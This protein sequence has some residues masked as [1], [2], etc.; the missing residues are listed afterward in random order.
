MLGDEAERT[1]PSAAEYLLARQVRTFVASRHHGHRVRTACVEQ[2]Y[3]EACG[4]IPGDPTTDE[5][6]NMQDDADGMRV[7]K[8]LPIGDPETKRLK[9]AA[10]VEIDPRNPDDLML[11]ID[12][13]GLIDIGFNVP[14]FIMP[15]DIPCR[16]ALVWDVQAFPDHQ[17]RSS[18]DTTSSSQAAS[19]VSYTTVSWGSPELPDDRGI[20]RGVRRQGLQHHPREEWITSTGKTPFGAWLV[21]LAGADGGAQV[22]WS[23]STIMAGS[24][25]N[26]LP[27]RVMIGHPVLTVSSRT[28]SSSAIGVG[29]GLTA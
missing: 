28:T 13:C 20:L 26:D 2:F 4:Y 1:A 10:F 29:L 9:I 15:D 27:H 6:G 7:T 12:E 19:G 14:A 25:M 5:G 11:A 8:G 21:G 22:T 23:R 17:H 3:E 24:R 18:V 16:R